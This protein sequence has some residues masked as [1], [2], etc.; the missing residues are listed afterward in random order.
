MNQVLQPGDTNGAVI[1]L[2][3][4]NANAEYSATLPQGCLHF[5]F[6][7]RTSYDVRF[8]F[9]TGKVAGPSAPYVTL[10]ADKAFSSPEKLSLKH[11][12]N[13]IYFAS[14][15]AGVVVEIVPW[16]VD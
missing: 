8:A 1:N 3:L 6:Q 12:R 2:T 4:T 9:V 5:S 11:D 7:C 16:V 15:Q 10:K 13:V 14:S